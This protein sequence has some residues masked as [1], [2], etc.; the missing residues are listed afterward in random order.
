VAAQ[1]YKIVALTDNDWRKSDEADYSATR[2]AA[3]KS[4][5]PLSCRWVR[6]TDNECG[7]IY[8]TKELG[9]DR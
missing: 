2:W 4:Y 9:W 8:A 7:D 3:A 5:V 6:L 1:T